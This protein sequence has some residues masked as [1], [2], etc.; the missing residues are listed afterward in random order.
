MWTDAEAKNQYLE[1]MVFEL[2]DKLE[3]YVQDNIRSRARIRTLQ[4]ELNLYKEVAAKLEHSVNNE[5]SV[6]EVSD[7]P[8]LRIPMPALAIQL[9]LDNQDFHVI[10][11]SYNEDKSSVAFKYYITK[12]SL[13]DKEQRINLLT[14][15]H[16][17]VLDEMVRLL[18]K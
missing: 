15:L 9:R 12:D 4:D 13:L 7:M 5:P 14:Y 10:A 2:S 11:K 6:V 17:R 8:E 3:K 16:K 1:N 18:E